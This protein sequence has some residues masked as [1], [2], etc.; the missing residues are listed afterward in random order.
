MEK[1]ECPICNAENPPEASS[2]RGCGYGLT[3]VSWPATSPVEVDGAADLPRISMAAEGAAGKDV[4][5]APSV[6]ES[7]EPVRRP[8]R[9]MTLPFTV[10]APVPLDGEEPGGKRPP[11]DI[12]GNVAPLVSEERWNQAAFVVDPQRP[13]RH[14][15]HSDLLKR[16]HTAPRANQHL[17][18]CWFDS[19]GS[20]WS[21][22]EIRN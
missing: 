11:S 12:R 21:D 18:L 13:C 6:P 1:S 22:R 8:T 15:H 7:P 17:H 20:C 9:A 16:A 10:E 2:C 4:E 14:A 3:K 5:I 19:R